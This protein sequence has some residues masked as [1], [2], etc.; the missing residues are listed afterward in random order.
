MI[1]ETAEVGRLMKVVEAVVDE[2]DRQ[3]FLDV[4]AYSGFDVTELVH[5]VIKAADG[6]V[7]PLRRHTIQ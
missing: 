6:D 4:L 3:G 2:L 1:D 7:V 5:A